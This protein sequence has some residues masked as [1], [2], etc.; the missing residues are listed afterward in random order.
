MS[1]V[2][3]NEVVFD[4]GNLLPLVVVVGCG[5]DLCEGGQAALSDLGSME[6]SAELLVP[7]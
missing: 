1:A 2:F 4:A 7:F 3:H 6:A 5:V